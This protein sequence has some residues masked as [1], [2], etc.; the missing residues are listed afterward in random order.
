MIGF[1]GYMRKSEIRKDYLLD[2][3][4]LIAPRRSKRP[5][6]I[7]ETAVVV[8]PSS[9]FT[10]DH[11]KKTKIIDS[12][13]TGKGQIVAIKNLYPAVT[14]QNKKAQGSQ[15]VIVDT[16]DPAVRL[17]DLSDEHITH[18][19]RMYGRR[20]KAISKLPKV[21]YVICFKNEGAS[22][23]A[24][25]QHEHSQVFG[26]SF[27][28][29]I[30]AEEETKLKEYHSIH[31]SDF[32]SDLIKKEIKGR[33][34][35]FEDKYIAAFTPYASLFQ[36]E[37]WIFTKRQVDSIADLSKQEYASL[38][39]LLKRIL[40]KLKKLG[41]PYNYSTRQIVSDSHQH[42]CLKIQPRGNVWAGIE[43]DAGLI[44]NP[45]APESA[46]SY[47]RKK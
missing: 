8:T 12:L 20:V 45:V 4:V 28:P 30:A 26:S 19:L 22:A 32:Y 21:E 9:P 16:P 18:L 11:L 42:F 25:V 5:E 37:V 39:K 46:A 36:Y 24:S 3:Y 10:P 34:R 27:I 38:A 33:R 7:K 6:Q 23:G 31:H 13:G 40:L 15:E 17:T 43:L 44:I 41:L 1:S 29:P 14:M 47:Y 2:R 35:V